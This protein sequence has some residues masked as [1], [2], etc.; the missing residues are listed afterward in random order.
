MMCVMNLDHIV[1]MHSQRDD[2]GSCT[3]TTDCGENGLES[4]TLCGVSPKLCGTEQ[5]VPLEVTEV[6]FC[7]VSGM[8]EPGRPLIGMHVHQ[9]YAVEMW[10]T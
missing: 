5:F 1:L 3:A 4:S 10:S 6:T 2:V 8:S 7:S 9:C